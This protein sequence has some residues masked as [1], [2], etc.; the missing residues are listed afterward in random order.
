M[1]RLHIGGE[2]RAS[3]WEVL[4]ALPGE[5]VDHVGDA[6]DLSRF[7]D[8]TFDE[9]YASHI[10]EH[11][12][13]KQVMDVLYEWYRVLAPGGRLS[14]AVPDLEAVF[15][16]FLASRDPKVR[17]WLLSVVYAS[18]TTPYDFHRTGFDQ[19]RLAYSLQA[20][21]LTDIE[22]VSGGFG[23]FDD[24]SNVTVNQFPISLN[25]RGRKPC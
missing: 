20:V 15:A 22:R 3:G 12:P 8:G 1:R 10:L 23:E 13:H 24:A 18:Q 6:A 19:G 16:L 17:G 4:N 7:E 25:L 11:F 14:V 2:V 21:G 9:V 5:H